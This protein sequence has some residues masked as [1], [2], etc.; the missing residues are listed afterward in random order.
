MYEVFKEL[1]SSTGDGRLLVC[2]DVGL[3]G[4]MVMVLVLV[5][6]NAALDG[7]VVMM[8]VC[9]DAALDGHVVVVIVDS[10]AVDVQ[11]KIVNS[12][13]KAADPVVADER[14]TVGSVVWGTVAAQEP[15]QVRAEVTGIC[16]IKA[17]L[18]SSAMSRKL[19]RHQLLVFDTLIL[20]LPTLGSLRS[21][22]DC[23]DYGQHQ[24]QEEC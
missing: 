14:P 4:Y 11:E 2:A 15:L 10:E 12:D 5:C 24:D 22:K 20:H 21:R 1:Q 23:R 3:D 9:A 8:L 18:S 19:S 7:H 13:G 16:R 17:L 6:A